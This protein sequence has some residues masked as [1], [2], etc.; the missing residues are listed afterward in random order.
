MTYQVVGYII[1]DGAPVR[2]VSCAGEWYERKQPP[3][4]Y[5]TQDV[6]KRYA[7]KGQTVKPVYVEV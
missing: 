2:N 4:I 6:A 7:S 5:K 3:K 1:W